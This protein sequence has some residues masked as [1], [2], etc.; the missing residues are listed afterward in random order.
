VLTAYNADGNVSSITAVNTATG[1]QVTQY[2]YGTTLSDSSIASSLLKRYEILPDSVSGSDQIA[3]TY[4]CQREVVTLTNQNGTVH[5]YIYDLLARKTQDCVTTLGTGV[6]SAVLRIATTY[7]VRGMVQNVTSYD[8]ATVGSGTVVN[9]V[10]M[11]YNNFGQLVTDFQSHSGAVNTSTTPNVQYA[12]DNGSANEIRP[13]TITYPNGRVLNY[14]Y[15]SS[16]A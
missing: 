8:N 4:D 3:L 12:Y 11:V 1:N 5:T 6:D 15:G 14:T 16:A 2:V 10:Q 13:T 7:E 9:D